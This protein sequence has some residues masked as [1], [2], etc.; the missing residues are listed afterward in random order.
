MHYLFDKKG[1]C[2]CKCPFCCMTACPCS[3]VK[4]HLGVATG[5]LYSDFQ[6]LYREVQARR[7]GSE[8]VALRTGTR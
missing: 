7:R 5:E 2:I 3:V 1:I 4:V 8:I 6:G